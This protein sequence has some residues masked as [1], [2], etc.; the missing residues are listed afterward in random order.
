M[1]PGCR[2]LTRAIACLVSETAV[3][4]LLPKLKCLRKEWYGQPLLFAKKSGLDHL[5]KTRKKKKKQFPGSA[6]LHGSLGQWFKQE[7]MT[8]WKGEENDERNHLHVVVKGVCCASVQT[9]DLDNE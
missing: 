1:L 5:P 6:L 3:Q 4:S 9:K 7:A 2:H 8:G